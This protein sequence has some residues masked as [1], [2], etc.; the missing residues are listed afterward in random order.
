MVHIKDERNTYK[1]DSEDDDANEEVQRDQD[2]V[3]PA[4]G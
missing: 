2:V 1:D 4:D 3:E